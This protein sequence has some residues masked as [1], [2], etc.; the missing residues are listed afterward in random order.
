[1]N[2]TQQLTALGIPED[3]AQ[4]LT[5]SLQM[6]AMVD[7]ASL[8]KALG[9]IDHAQAMAPFI[10]PT[11]LVTGRLKFERGDRNA[12]LLRAA[13]KLAQVLRNQGAAAG[14]GG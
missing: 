10:D 4:A 7:P 12:E 14:G 3:E 11:G 9:A 5:F 13:R 8:D 1:M 6:M 2:S